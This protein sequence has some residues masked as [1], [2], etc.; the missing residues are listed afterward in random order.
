MTR[1]RAPL[2]AG[3]TLVTGLTLI[4]GSHTAA[5]AHGLADGGALAGLSHPL[6]GVDHL[7]MLV[8]SGTAAAVVSPWLLAWALLGAAA[9]AVAGGQGLH[10]HGGEVLAA[11][12]IAAGALSALKASRLPTLCGLVVAGGMAIH[13]LLHGLEAPANVAG[14]QWWGGALLSSVLVCG[15]SWLLLRAASQRTRQMLAIGLVGS[16]M[17]LALAPLGQLNAG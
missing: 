3:V 7:L 16:G 1:F 14:L 11:L 4:L 5:M 9:G 10:L 17:L 8:T 12:A 15:A 13:G 2:T 6:L